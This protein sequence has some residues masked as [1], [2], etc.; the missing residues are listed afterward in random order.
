MLKFALLVSAVMFTTPAS[1]NRTSTSEA[2]PVEQV[3]CRTCYDIIWPWGGQHTFTPGAGGSASFYADCNVFNT[4]HTN[5]QVD[6]C[7]SYHNPCGS[8]ASAGAPDRALLALLD[9]DIQKTVGEILTYDRRLTYVAERQALQVTDC[10]GAVLASFG[11]YSTLGLAMAV[12]RQP[13]VSGVMFASTRR[14][15]LFSWTL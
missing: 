13:V 12:Y 4:C 10:E 1:L 6:Y 9:G 15:E 3:S 8:G 7:N 14:T 5:W 11:P 2:R